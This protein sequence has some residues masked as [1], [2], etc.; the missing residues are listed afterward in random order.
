MTCAERLTVSRIRT[1][2]R[3]S[4]RIS[5]IA[6]AGL[7]VVARERQRSVVYDDARDRTRSL[8]WTDVLQYFNQL[9][10]LSAN[11]S[12][13]R[14]EAVLCSILSSR[15]ERKSEVPLKHLAMF[16]NAEKSGLRYW[17]D[18]MKSRGAGVFPSVEI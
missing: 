4:A 11:R 2:V 1:D 15:N 7:L 5:E 9:G 16:Q 12:S 3:L 6:T 10:K 13:S 18:F 8:N 14:Q 17:T